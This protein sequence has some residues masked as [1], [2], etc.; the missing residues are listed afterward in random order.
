MLSLIDLEKFLEQV[1]HNSDCLQCGEIAVIASDDVELEIFGWHVNKEKVVV[2]TPTTFFMS[3]LYW[4]SHGHV[5]IE[6]AFLNGNEIA[7]KVLGILKESQS[8]LDGLRRVYLYKEQIMFSPL[9]EY[10]LNLSQREIFY[11]LKSEKPAPLIA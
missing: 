8:K 5:G 10:S 6:T 3:M 2:Y 11:L 1:S 7:L 9:A 4:L